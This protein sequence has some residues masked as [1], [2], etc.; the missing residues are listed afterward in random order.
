MAN[1]GTIIAGGTLGVLAAR[2]LTDNLRTRIFQSLGLCT[3][4][5]G[6]DMAGQMHNPLVV[7]FSLLLGGICGELL[8]VERRFEELGEYLKQR[9]RSDNAL[10]TEGFVTGTLI[11]CVGAM[12]IVGAFDEGLRGDST[13]LLTKALL[14]GFA[15]V[16]L[17]ATY[18]IGVLFA[19]IP[20]FLY[21]YGLTLCAVLAQDIFS[22]V[23][24]DQL[25]ATGGILIVGIS[26]NLLD[27]KR[28]PLTCFLPALVCVVP[29]AM[30]FG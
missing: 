24:I 26:I 18:G 19:A 6:I 23:M 15:A 22:P 20:V 28:L 10:F 27:I 4:V 2:Y 1:V 30:L 7:I 8:G 9:I 5:M 29:L 16:A 3:L 12:A 25:T 11:F 13:V 17:A 21:Q 14:D